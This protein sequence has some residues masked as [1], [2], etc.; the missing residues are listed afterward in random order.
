MNQK[1]TKP[2]ADFVWD[3][4]FLIDQ[5]LTDDERMLR[6][7]TRE[8]AQEKLL[9]RVVEAYRNETTDAGIFKEMGEMG[10]LGV[11]VPEQYGG[12]GANYVS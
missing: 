9:P 6:D 3:D 11:T 12:I 4:P 10:L 5:Q 8:F 2:T 7:A 1:S